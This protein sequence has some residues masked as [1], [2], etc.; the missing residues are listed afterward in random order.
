MHARS[1]TDIYDVVCT[2]DS[3]LIVF[4]HQ[5]RIA[6]VAQVGEGGEQSLVVALVQADGG[7]VKDVHHADQPRADLGCQ[8]N[9]LRLAPREGFGAA[10]EGQ[11]V[12]AHIHQEAV[13]CPQFLHDLVGDLA[14]APLQAKLFKIQLGLAHRH[15]GDTGQRALIHEHVAGVAAQAGA[16]ALGAGVVGEKLR[17][18]LA[19]RRGIRVAIAPLHVGNNPFESV[20]APEHVA[21]VVDV[22]KGDLLLA[23]ALQDHLPVFLVQLLKRRINVKAVVLRQGGKHVE[24]IDIAPVPAADRALRQ[25]GLGVQHDA[26]RIEILAYAEAVATGAGAR[27]VVERE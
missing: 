14:L 1:G 27:R 15:A 25:A 7:L 3:V 18:F 5:Y 9:P 21:P 23:T 19:H 2:A 10:I 26:L 11:V 16:L 13:A 12:E 24:V 6:Q 8:A 17:E 20:G 22:G 4:H